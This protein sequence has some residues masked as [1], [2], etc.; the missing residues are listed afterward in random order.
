MKAI[1]I[2][3]FGGVDVFKE[4]TLSLPKIKPGHVL[5][6]VMATSVNPLDYKIRQ[7]HLPSLV[8][9]F[10]HV[11]HG[12]V[13]GV[14]EQVGDGV[15]SFSVGDAVY[16]CA[17]GLLEMD[18]ALAEFMLVD[19]DLIAHKPKSID[20]LE[21]AALPLVS[22]TAW[23]A[24]VTYS[25]LQKNQNVLIHGGT[26]GVGHLAIQLAKCFGAKV[27]TTCSSADKMEIAKQLGA[28]EV[29]NYK[30]ESV[31]SYVKKHTSG[32]GFDVVFDTLGEDNLPKCFEA[33]SLFGKVVSIMAMG[34]YDLSQAF[35]KGLTLHTVMQPLPLLTGKR[36]PEYGRILNAI[37]NLVD[38]GKIKPLVDKNKFSI[39]E[40]AAAHTY[41]EQGH[42]VGKVVL[43]K[44]S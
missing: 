16:G 6:K 7:G 41:L 32:E 36:R 20:F 4:I 37:S 40:V 26:G 29:I 27:F 38:E 2:T 43:G 23:E 22:L 25:N 42:A 10:P 3:G 31:E 8:K 13:S 28:D 30:E 39:E 33:A 18:G 19:Q 1:A 35:F 24:L 15:S 5:I 12:D 11:L 14:V 9:S 44:L 21:A 17:G 34:N